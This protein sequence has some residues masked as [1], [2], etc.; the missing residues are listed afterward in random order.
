MVSL[1]KDSVGILPAGALGVSFFYHLTKQA[2]QVDDQVYF[3]ERQNS[4]S[5]Q[6]LKK[7]GEIAIAT[8]ETIKYFSTAEILKPDLLSCYK[9]AL[10]PE[11]V[12]I[13]P[14]PDQLLSI[15]ST[16]VELL[17]LISEQG[18]LSQL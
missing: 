4:S 3:L 15:I 8:S 17:I 12:L 10:L 18:E 13:C 11:I 1:I 14:N 6:A 16:A 2:T 9:L 7:S 5:S